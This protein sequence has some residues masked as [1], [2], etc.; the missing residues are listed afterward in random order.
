VIIGPADDPETEAMVHTALGRSRPNLTLVR[1][2]PGAAPLP[3]L[4]PAAGKTMVKERPTAYLCREQHC[5]AP[6]TAATDLA[7]L[8]TG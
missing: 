6:V 5:S 3:S 8:L 1:R 4:H 2:K 7:V